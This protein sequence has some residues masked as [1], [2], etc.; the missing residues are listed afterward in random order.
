MANRYINI[1]KNKNTKG[2]NEQHQVFFRLLVRFIK[3]RKPDNEIKQLRSELI[4]LTLL[5]N[6]KIKS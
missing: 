2:L 6:S 5:I 3:T 4:A 1:N